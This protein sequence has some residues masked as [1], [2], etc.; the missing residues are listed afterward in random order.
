MHGFDSHWHIFL[1]LAFKLLKG[2]GLL[3]GVLAAFG[4]RKLV[5]KWRQGHAA[6]GWPMT[7]ATIQ[8]GKVHS[9]GPR[10]YWVEVTYSYFVNEY[11]SG[12]YV[13]H[14]KREEDASDFI[15][16]TRDKRV[17]VRYKESA[18][19]TSTILDRDLDMIVLM[20]PQYS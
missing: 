17:M 12:T 20:A 8:W 10:Q 6:S 16:H 14:F 5:Q 19:D 9:D 15:R 11:R 13:R 2:F 3:P 1:P 7:E 18:P 4:V